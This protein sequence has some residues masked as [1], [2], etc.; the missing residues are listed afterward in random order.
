[1]QIDELAEIGY[2]LRG[3]VRNAGDVVVINEKSRGPVGGSGHFLNIDYRAVGYAA[4]AIK[5]FPPFSFQ[6]VDGLRFAAQ[7]KVGD[8]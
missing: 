1:M 6:V 2:V 3:F 7:Q 8:G 4:D 5:P